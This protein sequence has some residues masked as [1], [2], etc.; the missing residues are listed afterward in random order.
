VAQGETS[1]LFS[2]FRWTSTNP[3]FGE[4]QFYWNIQ[5]SILRLC[6]GIPDGFE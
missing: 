6:P 1:A 4:S 5:R 3:P 2:M